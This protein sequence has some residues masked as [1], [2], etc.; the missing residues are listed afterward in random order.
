MTDPSAMLER[1]S[2]LEAK[3]TKGPWTTDAHY[4]VAEVPTGRP[5]G[6][7]IVNCSP[8]V[9]RLR[10][11][12]PSRQTADFI[13]TLRNALPDLLALARAGIEKNAVAQE[14]ES[15]PG[16]RVVRA[17]LRKAR[18]PI[19]SSEDK[20]PCGAPMARKTEGQIA[21]QAAAA[22]QKLST[23]ANKAAKSERE[24]EFAAEP[25]RGK[26]WV[27]HYTTCSDG[28]FRCDLRECIE[29]MVHYK[30]SWHMIR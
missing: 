17:R 16:A 26:E 10:D 19:G 18:K 7:V 29:V 23:L 28:D 12:L 25:W 14:S 27:A 8:T 5:G 2:E 24:R 1:L 11:K 30:N 9:G 6:E 20:N 3:A 4:I 22:L 21:R 15:R 13:A